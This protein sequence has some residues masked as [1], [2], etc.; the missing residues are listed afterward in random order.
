MDEKTVMIQELGPEHLKAVVQLHQECFAPETNFS[1]RLGPRFLRASYNFFVKDP[2]AFGFVALY[3]GKTVGFICGRLDF[4]VGAL[5]RYRAPVAAL[6]LLGR[7]RLLFAMDFRKRLVQAVKTFT[8]RR[9]TEERKSTNATREGPTATLASLGALP[10]YA[11]LRVSD[12][13]LSTAES[14]CRKQQ[15][16]FVRASV[17]RANISSR[18]LYRKRGY[19]EDP[20]TSTDDGV[21]CYLSLEDEA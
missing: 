3:E 21:F 9:K 6:A 7:P 8:A 13:L 4:F 17:R 16:H 11:H 12:R 18:F 10:D 5:N 14:L 19:V 15:M 2:K 1:T 20:G